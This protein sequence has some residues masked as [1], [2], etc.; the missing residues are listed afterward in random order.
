VWCLCV[1]VCGV[2]VVFVCVCVCGVCVFVCVVLVTQHAMRMLHTVTCPAVQYFSILSINSTI[3]VKKI[4]E[5][6]MFVLIFSSFI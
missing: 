1:C 2:C 6:K 5:Y 4:I 3:L